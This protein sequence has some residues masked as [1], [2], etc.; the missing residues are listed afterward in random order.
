MK[1][2]SLLGVIMLVALFVVLV[3]VNTTQAG[4]FTL[5]NKIFFTSYR[6]GNAE[7]YSMNPDGSFQTRLTN[8]VAYDG[9]PSCSADTNK[10][11]FVSDRAGNQEIY[12]MNS[13]GTSFNRKTYNPAN[14]LDPALAADGTKIAFVSER[15]EN[16][17]LYI[18]A[19]NGTGL[20]RLTYTSTD[21]R[22]PAWSPDGT[23]LAFA[24]SNGIWVMDADGSNARSLTNLSGA[25]SQPC[26]SPQGDK[27]AFSVE[28]DGNSE[29][30]VIHVN[31]SGLTRLTEDPAFDQD[32][33]WSPDGSKIVFTSDRNGNN[34]LFVI[35]ATDG[36]GVTNLTYN[37]ANDEEPCW[38]G[39][40]ALT[41]PIPTTTVNPTP[42]LVSIPSK[43]ET[44]T[45]SSIPAGRMGIVAVKD[46]IYRF[47][48]WNGI[49]A[50]IGAVNAVQ[51][52]DPAANSWINR[53]PLPSGTECWGAGTVAIG[54]D[55]FIIG[56]YNYISHYFRTIRKY[57]TTS[58][59]WS[60]CNTQLNI[61]RADFGTA[62][63]NNKIYIIGGDVGYVGPGEW[64]VTNTIEVFDPA[65]MRVDMATIK[66]AI[67]KD[68][69]GTVTIGT[70]VY[71]IG[72]TDGKYMNT[73]NSV[74]I[75]DP[76]QNSYTSDVTAMQICR[77]RLAAVVVNGKIYA[78]GGTDGKVNL[79][80]VEEYDPINGWSYK[81]GMPTA[82]QDVGVAV[83]ANK[84]YAIGGTTDAGITGVTEEY[85]P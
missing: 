70:K 10:F 40:A 44:M 35:S 59:T 38:G 6:D 65:A 13:D 16:Y 3:A 63:I 75:F 83:V 76:V 46:K 9:Q 60:T 56:G 69:F 26:W 52:Y 74:D 72:G 20:T 81:P 22:Y 54:D 32:P 47:G 42:T 55:I 37:L 5:P 29:I 25:A 80:T 77:S 71:I 68:L 27:V 53:S 49:N 23:K 48:G 24:A 12:S 4:L 11:V 34:E 78:I 41:S 28:M 51:V 30:Y 21:E 19:F 45:P 8:N 58:N 43:W 17:E 73:K 36:T 67:G 84:I 85:T 79:N 31:G 82:R 64:K 66:M 33:S 15:D 18:M 7:I 57:N 14:D 50:G 62:I 39:M 61:G 2:W 1:K